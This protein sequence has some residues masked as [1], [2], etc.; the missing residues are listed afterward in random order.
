MRL[1]SI[2]TKTRHQNWYPECWKSYVMLNDASGF[3]HVYLCTGYTDLRKGIDGL[4][5]IVTGTFGLD[6][7]EA[8][9]IFLF[10]GRRMTGWKSYSTKAM[11][12][13]YA[14]KDLPMENFNGQEVKKKPETLPLNSTDADGRTFHWTEKSNTQGETRAFISSVFIYVHW[15]FYKLSKFPW[16]AWNKGFFSAICGIMDSW[17]TLL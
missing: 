6:P 2:W 11:A 13:F 15:Q 9:S 17:K 14:I 16:N 8:G 7:T 4:I 10:C 12:G 5:S 3:Q 1:S